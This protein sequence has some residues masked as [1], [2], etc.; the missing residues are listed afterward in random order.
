VSREINTNTL[1]ILVL[2]VSSAGTAEQ[3][4]SHIIPDG[5]PVTITARPTNT[6][7]MYV[8]NSKANAEG[9]A[10]EEFA[11]GRS[12]TY[13]VDDTDRFWIDADNTSDRLE[14]RIPTIS[15]QTS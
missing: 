10:R 1:T 3:V 8:G 13:R 9:T 4:A 12:A 6:G 11:F 7:T 15:A 14:F 5:L 2:G